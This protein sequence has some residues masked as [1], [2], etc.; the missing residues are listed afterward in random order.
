M[1]PP[2][3]ESHLFGDN[4]KGASL[5][6]SNAHCDLCRALTCINCIQCPI[7]SNTLAE[8]FRLCPRCH[9][10]YISSF[11]LIHR[12]LINAAYEARNTAYLNHFGPSAALPG[13]PRRLD[14]VRIRAAQ[15]RILKDLA[16]GYC[17]Q[18]AVDA[19]NKIVENLELER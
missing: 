16:D 13:P 7:P 18:A 6:F 9:T 11:D 12:V 8:V 19:F 10:L 1:D 5:S 17:T 3:C 4:P 15:A 14:K 2:I